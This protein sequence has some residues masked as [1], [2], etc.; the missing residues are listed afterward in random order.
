MKFKFSK[1]CSLMF[2]ENIIKKYSINCYNLTTE[3]Q[4]KDH[5]I[6]W[7]K[8]YDSYIAE[9][10]KGI[11]VFDRIG[12]SWCLTAAMMAESMLDEWEKTRPDKLQKLY[13]ELEAL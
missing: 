2:Y 4:R 13:D 10:E 6:G 3:K 5:V 8:D 11:I 12:L 7:L 9:G 1:H